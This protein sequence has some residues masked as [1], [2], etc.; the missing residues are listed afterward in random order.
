MAMTVAECDRMI[1]ACAD[2]GVTLG[3]AYY[4]RFTR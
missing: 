2:A 1:A 3:L 4:R